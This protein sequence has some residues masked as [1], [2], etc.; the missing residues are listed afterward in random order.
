LSAPLISEK[1]MSEDIRYFLEKFPM[2]VHIRRTDIIQN[3]RSGVQVDDFWKGP[4]IFEDCK[5]NMNKHSGI[6]LNATDYPA[7]H[8]FFKTFKAGETNFAGSFSSP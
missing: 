5:F 6:I 4:L 2:I 1:P 7:D 8:N 3:G